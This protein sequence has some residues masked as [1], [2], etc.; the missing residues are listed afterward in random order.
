M[1]FTGLVAR[2]RFG[3]SWMGIIVVLAES[4]LNARGNPK[5]GFIECLTSRKKLDGN[6]RLVFIF[7]MAVLSKISRRRFNLGFTL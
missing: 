1:G 7:L 5:L 6:C 2:R 4:K 3:K